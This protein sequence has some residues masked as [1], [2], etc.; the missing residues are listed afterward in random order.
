VDLQSNDEG[1][2]LGEEVAAIGNGNRGES[3]CSPQT[4]IDQRGQIDYRQQTEGFTVDK[5]SLVG[6]SSLEQSQFGGT[7]ESTLQGTI[8]DSLFSFR[9]DPQPILAGTE[10]GSVEQAADI[11]MQVRSKGLCLY[12]VGIYVMLS[13]AFDSSDVYKLFYHTL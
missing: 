12:T 10:E 3:P 2:G 6:G 11:I 7:Q 9:M 4:T 8:L 1:L 5:D 13:A